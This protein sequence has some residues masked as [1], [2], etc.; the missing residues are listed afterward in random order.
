MVLLNIGSSRVLIFKNMHKQKLK[1]L[2]ITDVKNNP[3]D[4]AS[5]AC[6]NKPKVGNN[7]KELHVI[8]ATWQTNSKCTQKNM[9]ITVSINP[10]TYGLIIIKDKL[11][12][13]CAK[14][15]LS[16]SC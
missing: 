8:K 5:L 10:V 16:L 13:S 1:L 4:W 2:I 7:Y 9:K 14:L 6:N 12:L 3:L 15:M 11:G